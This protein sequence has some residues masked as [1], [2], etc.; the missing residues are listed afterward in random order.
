M[1]STQN[2]RFKFTCWLSCVCLCEVGGGGGGGGGTNKG[3]VCNLTWEKN[4][5]LKTSEESCIYIQV[6]LAFSQELCRVCTRNNDGD[7]GTLH[8]KAILTVHTGAVTLT[9]TLH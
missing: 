1:A 8:R 4:K 3:W 2:S 7:Y 9:V 6:S 5:I